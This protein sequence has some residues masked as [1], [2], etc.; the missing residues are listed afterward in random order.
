MVLVWERNTLVYTSHLSQLGMHAEFCFQ[1][2]KYIR[3]SLLFLI[4]SSPI[5][6]A[7]NALTLLYHIII[8][9]SSIFCSYNI[10]PASFSDG[11]TRRFKEIQINKEV[12]F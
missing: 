11:R 12:A 3:M 1:T 10:I 9:V 4:A 6:M 7:T 8:P 2:K 5:S